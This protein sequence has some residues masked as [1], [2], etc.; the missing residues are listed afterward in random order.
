MVS[1][2]DIY[3]IDLNPTLGAEIQKIRPC[4]VVSPNELNRYLRTIIICP[5]TSK[6]HGYPYRVK[7]RVAEKDGEIA[8]DQIR[9]IDR[10]R[11]KDKIGILTPEEQGLLKQVLQEMFG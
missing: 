9:T 2:F 7:C 5:I 1:R 11:I 3:W 8:T 10:Q 4:V 6:I